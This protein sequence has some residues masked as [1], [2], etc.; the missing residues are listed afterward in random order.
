MYK[1][2][3]PGRAELADAVE[4]PLHGAALERGGG[5][6]EQQAPGARGQRPG[7][8]DDLPLLDGEARRTAR[9]RPRRSPTRS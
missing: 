1:I 3:T 4:Q 9:R 2:A 7:D 6:V 8:L 5:L